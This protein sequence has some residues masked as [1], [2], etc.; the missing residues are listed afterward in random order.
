MKTCLVVDDSDHL[1][2]IAA[3][4]IATFGLEV[5]EAGGGLEA[6]AICR[7]RMPDA[8][9]LDWN[10]PGM[11]G[12]EFLRKLA[13]ETQGPMPQV[14]FCSAE[15]GVRHIVDALAAGAHDY[16]IKPFDRELL[17]AKFRAAGLID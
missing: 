6:L 17:R 15:A 14:I 16:V 2:G 3:K 9:L 7:D 5:S 11:T 10:M 8:I 1:R 13:G 12:I 4:V